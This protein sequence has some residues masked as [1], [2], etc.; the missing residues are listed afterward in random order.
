MTRTMWIILPLTALAIL[1]MI[2]MVSRQPDP[3]AAIPYAEVDAESLAREPRM[4]TAEYSTVTDDGTRLTLTADTA[5]PRGGG[6][7]NGARR[8]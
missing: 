8:Q 3:D 6:N 4:N 7:S 1:S 5:K 2:F